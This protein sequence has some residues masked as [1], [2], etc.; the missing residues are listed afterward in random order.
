MSGMEL[1]FNFLRFTSAHQFQRNRRP[2]G[3]SVFNLL[4]CS[5]F[6]EH[7]YN[8]SSLSRHATYRPRKV[9]TVGVKLPW[10]RFASMVVTP[11]F[12][13]YKIKSQCSLCLCDA[14]RKSAPSYAQSSPFIINWSAVGPIRI[15]STIDFLSVPQGNLPI[16]TSE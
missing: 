7:M 11:Y 16:S 12:E 1:F 2:L 4:T 5:F 3:I 14:G 15:L 13:T 8:I 10:K 9:L 6:D